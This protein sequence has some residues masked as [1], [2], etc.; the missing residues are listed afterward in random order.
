MKFVV[1]GG[2]GFIGSHVTEQ[3]LN[4]GHSVTV[5]DNFSTGR[6]ENLPSSISDLPTSSF[7]LPQLTVLEKD[8]RDLSIKD[9][10]QTIDAIA[11]LAAVPSVTRS[12][13]EPLSVHENNLSATV[14]VIELARALKIPKIVFASSAAVYGDCKDQP[15][16]EDAPKNPCSPYG[17]QKLVSEMYGQMFAEKAGLQFIALRLFNVYGPR[18]RPDSPYSGVISI[19]TDAMKHAKAITVYGDGSQT[20]D[21]V[22]VSDVASAFKTA[23]VEQGGEGRFAAYNIATGKTTSIKELAQVLRKNFPTWPEKIESAPARPGDITR[24]E[25]DVSKAAAELGFKPTVSIGAGLES[26]V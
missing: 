25:A 4:A 12:W 5:V 23:L 24:S 3:L 20:R 14:A 6:R 10:S 9:F 11:H 21:F 26:V 15:I 13:D 1:T 17:L 18:Q 8:V 7:D 19:F 22:H 2:A 16:R